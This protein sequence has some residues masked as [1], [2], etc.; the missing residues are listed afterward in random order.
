MRPLARSLPLVFLVY[1]ACAESEPAKRTPFRDAPH[2]ASAGRADGGHRDAS[3]P[4][5]ASDSGAHARDAGGDAGADAGGDAGADAGGDAGSDS[6]AEVPPP[7]APLRFVVLGDG[8]TG[9]EAQKK[10]AQAMARICAERGCEFALYLGDN[11]YDDGVSGVDDEQFLLKFEEPYAALD[12]PFYVAL[13]NHD[14]GSSGTNIFPEDAKSTAQVEYTA[15]SAKWTM[16]HY[17]Y[18]FEHGQAAFF[19]L[20]TNAIV[21]DQFRG[22]NEQQTWLDQEMVKS[23]TAWKIVFGHHPYVSNGGHGNAGEYGYPFGFEL[24][25]GATLKALVD[26]SVCGKADLFFA[27]HDHHREWLEPTCGTTFIVSGA[28]A[29]LRA[30]GDTGS[31]SFWADDQKRGFLW[32]E[33]DGDVMTGVFFD[34]EAQIDFEQVVMR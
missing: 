21:M 9:D 15:H 29:K 19:A 3:A 24:H 30:V 4:A 18:T 10:V 2:D 31:P 26:E 25:S 28:A 14:Y 22:L 33:L 16:P 12:F 34:D 27:G 20:D 1:A 23:Q 11:I 17:Y 5:L 7:P 13:G 8:G 32:V 6:G